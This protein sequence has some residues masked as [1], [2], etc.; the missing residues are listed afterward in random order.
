M[1]RHSWPSVEECLPDL[2][3]L[4]IRIRDRPETGKLT[5]RRAKKA[6]KKIKSPYRRER[7]LLKQCETNLIAEVV[8]I[9]L[10]IHRPPARFVSTG[11]PGGSQSQLRL[12]R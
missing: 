12:K 9:A 2:Q 5:R 11:T 8:L 4:I 7:N 1:L 10:T 3:R 6:V